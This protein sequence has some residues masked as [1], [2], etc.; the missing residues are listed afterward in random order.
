MIVRRTPWDDPAG[1]TLRTAQRAELS[2]RYQNPNS[3]PGPAP[4]A[5]DITLFLV[6]S[7]YSLCHELVLSPRT[8]GA[9]G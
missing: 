2:D 7:E 8:G 9:S 4:A 1:V 6:D 3:E 5:E